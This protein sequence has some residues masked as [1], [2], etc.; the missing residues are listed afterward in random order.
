MRPSFR[1]LM[2]AASSAVLLSACGSLPEVSMSMPRLPFMGGGGQPAPTPAPAPAPT[3]AATTGTPSQP[4]PQAASDVPAD[5][6]VRYGV[7]PN[8]MRYA[9]MR[10]ATPPGQAS[11]RL[12]IDAG[13]LME[14]P[15]QLGLAHFMEHMAFNG[16]TDIPEGELVHTL[17]RLGL[18]F[19]ADTNASTDFD[20]TVYKLDLPRTDDTTV[21]ASL[22]ILREMSGEATLAAEAI[23]RER[24]VVLSEERTR[25]GPALRSIRARLSFLMKGQLAPDRFPI[26]DTSVLQSAP[27][28][29]FVDFYEAYY[30][31]E[32]TTLIAV[33]DFDVDQMEA[34]IRAEFGGWSNSHANGAEPSLGAVQSRGPEASVFVDPGVQSTLQLAWVS[35]PD[36]APDTLAQQ[37]KD[38]IRLL[39]LQVLNRRFQAL[40]RSATPPFIGAQGNVSTN[41]RS[42][43]NA[44]LYANFQPGQWRPAL[45]ALEQEQRRIVEYGVSPAEL[46]R[47]I[48]EFRTSLQNAVAGA[49]TRRTPGLANGL[50][51][52]VNE[53]SVFTA[54]QT[55]LA[56]FD[57]IVD[58][59]TAETVNAALKDVFK[60]SGP[61]VFITSPTAIEGGDQA[62][63][64]ALAEASATQI[65][66]PQA[67]AALTWPYTSFGTA[68]AVT[69]R[70]EVADI[71][72]T[73]VTFANGVKLTI[74]PTSF[75]DDQVMVSVRAGRG[76]LDLPAD[77]TT[78]LWA[79][80]STFG[81]GGLG[82][83]TAQQLEETLAANTYGMSFQPGEDSYLLSGSTRPADLQLQLQVLTAY[84]TDAAWRPDPFERI[85]G[86]YAQALPEIEATPAGVFGRDGEALLHS[87]DARWRF[88]SQSDIAGA[89]LS[90]LRRTVEKDLSRGPIEVIVVGDVDVDDVIAKVGSTLGA[91]PARTGSAERV[92]SGV[93]FP[94]GTATPVELKHG[95]RLD[96]ALGF[97]AW[98]TIDSFSDPRQMRYVR[99]LTDVLRLRLTDELRENQGVTYSPQVSDDPSA[100]FQGYGYVSAAIEAP[101]ERL[102]GFFA[103]VDR[104]AA[105][106]AANGVTADELE[107]ARRPRVEALLRM[108]E[109]NE[110]WMS[111][112]QDAQTDPARLPALRSAL[113]DLERATPADLQRMAQTYFVPAK[114]YRLK[115][116]PRV[117]AD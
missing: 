78:P 19:G 32:R 79:A 80:A 52:T 23:D 28:E 36:L 49:A 64:T 76:F 24:G 11:L 2:T 84:L 14:R 117:A 4:W 102:D 58:G 91:L 22:H 66:A 109:T 99:L 6:A 54:P 92:G 112:L 44:S 26:G 90:A 60:G 42:Q 41:W 62:V 100:V 82:R 17:E 115:V 34:K 83:L 13:S 3:P 12:R 116:T 37:E 59:L 20:E 50:V 65:A 73:F 89:D 87:G 101:P 85:R 72:T 39:G 110:F 46:A 47:E 21:D 53:R 51:D 57:T 94:A 106:I 75:R 104:I 98:P 77:R 114:A 86:V 97:V 9:L 63:L 69:A 31:P 38:V 108:R 93:T 18:S 113:A 71:E 8:G 16:S 30:R 15:D 81:E 111:E 56:I 27:R 103:D 29:R 55:D 35:P 61:L 48:T 68:S 10:N 74:K 1:L 43:D 25:D 40:S 107:R 33:G 7:L 95:G 105:E 88:P 67:E 70:S 96:Q 45:T 5:P